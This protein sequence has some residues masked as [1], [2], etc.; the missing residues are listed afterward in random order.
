MVRHTNSTEVKA[1]ISVQTNG[2]MYIGIE[3]REALGLEYNDK[4]RVTVPRTGEPDKEYT[5][6]LSS[7]NQFPTGGQKTWQELRQFNEHSVLHIDAIVEKAHGSWEDDH[8]LT[9]E[10]HENCFTLDMKL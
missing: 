1:E 10:R 3:A 4:V 5:G 9:A 8:K 6:F 7:S 2:Q